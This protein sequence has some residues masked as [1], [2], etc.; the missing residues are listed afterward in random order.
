MDIEDFLPIDYERILNGYGI[1]SKF[2]ISILILFIKHITVFNLFTVTCRLIEC[3][4][5]K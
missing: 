5:R 1:K 3:G 2:E 4:A